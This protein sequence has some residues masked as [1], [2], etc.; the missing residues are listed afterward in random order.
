MFMLLHELGPWVGVEPALWAIGP[1]VGPINFF[2][3]SGYSTIQTHKCV[4]YPK[5]KH[6]NSLAKSL[7]WVNKVLSL[8]QTLRIKVQEVGGYFCVFGALFVLKISLLCLTKMILK[9]QFNNTLLWKH[10]KTLFL[11]RLLHLPKIVI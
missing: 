4:N 2:L 9:I 11:E 6:D 8:L 5:P 3:H 10:L 1:L 7:V